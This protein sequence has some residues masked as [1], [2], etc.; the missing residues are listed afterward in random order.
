MAE[1]VVSLAR[2]LGL[3]RYAVLGHSYGAFVALQN[4]VD[5][6]GMA[7]QTIVSNGVPAAKY[8]AAVEKN[9]AAFEPTHLRAQVAA[10]RERESS[11]QTPED[12]AAVVH[13]Q[14]TFHFADP[15][16]PRIV[17][18]ERQ[19]AGTVYSPQVLRVFA[20]NDYGSIDAED[21][22][23]EVTRPMLVLAG[24]HDRTCTVEAAEAIANGVPGAELVIFEQSG[25]M[26]FVEEPEKYLDTV[27]RF[28]A[29]HREG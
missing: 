1:D 6:P 21:R 7:A 22:L 28:L 20:T 18:Y 23:G 2:A 8:L 27:D 24:R 17:E 25:H 10:S 29:P 3:G 16:D 5:F 26:T 11:V 19:T 15:A 9:L 13:D 14:W 4:A 12:F